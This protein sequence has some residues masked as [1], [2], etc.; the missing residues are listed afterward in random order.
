MAW[1]A[2]FDSNSSAVKGGTGDA[3]FQPEQATLSYM[4]YK[5]LLMMLLTSAGELRMC[6]M[7][8]RIWGEGTEERRGG[9]SACSSTS[10]HLKALGV[11]IP[12]LAI[13]GG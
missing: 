4:F 11:N 2:E 10:Y 7:E 8:G 1:D 9:S 12:P 13:G 5:C 6:G 3:L